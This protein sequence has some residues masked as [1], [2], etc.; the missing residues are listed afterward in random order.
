MSGGDGVGH[1]ANKQPNHL[2]L[3]PTASTAPPPTVMNPADGVP[4][5]S[6]TQSNTHACLHTR[7]RTQARTHARTHAL[8]VRPKRSALGKHERHLLQHC[9]V[10]E[11]RA[12]QSVFLK[13]SP[14]SQA[15][16]VGSVYRYPVAVAERSQLVHKV[17]VLKEHF[18]CASTIQSINQ[19][20]ARAEMAMRRER[21]RQGPSYDVLYHGVR[22]SLASSSSSSLYL[23]ALWLAVSRTH[24]STTLQTTNKQQ[25]HDDLNSAETHTHTHTTYMM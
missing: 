16:P 3:E 11:L 6:Y 25:L 21:S 4:C 2:S 1:R 14:K 23:V 5:A 15:H 8:V 17:D 22:C 20:R 12:V 7:T 19:R 18:D 10:F 13:N 24:T 9:G